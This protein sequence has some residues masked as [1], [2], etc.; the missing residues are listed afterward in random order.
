MSSR[1]ALELAREQGLD[2][3][4]VATEAQPVVCKIIDYGR[5]KYTTE[6]QKKETR[7]K[8]QDV[9]GIKFGPNSAEHD[10]GHL[11]KNAKKFLE[12]GH[13]VKVTCQFRRREIAHPELGKRKMEYFV[14]QLEDH[15]I[16]ENQPKLEGKL[17]TMILSPKPSSASKKHG[18]DQTEDKQN[19]SQ[20]I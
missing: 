14:Q 4:A 2:L 10:L 16:V 17:M 1:A 19:S 11:L 20:E 6:K 8:Q 12:E 15:C 18:K 7:K 3:V 13:K 5:F 9:K